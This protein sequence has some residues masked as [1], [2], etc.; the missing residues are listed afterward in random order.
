VWPSSFLNFFMSKHTKFSEIYENP[1]S[2][3]GFGFYIH[4]MHVHFPNQMS[5]LYTG[6]TEQIILTKKFEDGGA[7]NF[8]MRTGPILMLTVPSEFSCFMS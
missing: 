3:S 8:C 7:S 2:C 5:L 4:K 6:G 1:E